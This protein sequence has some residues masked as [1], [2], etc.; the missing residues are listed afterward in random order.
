MCHPISRL[1]TRPIFNHIPHALTPGSEFTLNPHHHLTNL[2]S[3]LSAI[4]VFSETN[5]ELI[6]GTDERL[7]RKAQTSWA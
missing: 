7:A 4:I 3:N 2:T 6:A 5:Q 1:Q